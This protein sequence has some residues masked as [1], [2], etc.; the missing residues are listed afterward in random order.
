M[1][2]FRFP[3]QQQPNSPFQFL[4]QE[5]TSD[6]SKAKY[7]IAKYGDSILRLQNDDL[8]RFLKFYIRPALAERM[9]QYINNG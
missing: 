6:D 1:D 8:N 3:H 5:S 9:K 4:Q 7:L 2:I